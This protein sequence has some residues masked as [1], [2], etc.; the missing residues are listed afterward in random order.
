M[1]RHVRKVA[2][3]GQFYIWDYLAE[4]KKITATECAEI[5]SDVSRATINNDL[6]KM[7]EL[8]LIHSGGASTGTYYESNF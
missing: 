6:S 4:R 8:G 2:L 7:Q 5:F 1:R 3:R